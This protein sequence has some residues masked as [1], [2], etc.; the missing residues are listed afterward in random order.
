MIISR[1][2]G[3]KY[4]I[5]SILFVILSFNLFGCEGADESANVNISSDMDIPEDGI[6]KADVFSAIAGTKEEITF[7]GKD[8][9]IE[10]EWI[11]SGENIHNPADSNLSIDFVTDESKLLEIK[12]L[13]GNPTYALGLKLDNEE[14]VTIPTL[15]ITLPYKWDADVAVLC[16]N[17]NNTAMKLSDAEVKV[18]NDSTTLTMQISEAN[19]LYYVVA[20][21]SKETAKERNESQKASEEKD[22]AQDTESTNND[23]DNNNSEVAD[24]NSEKNQVTDNSSKKNK[25]SDNKSEKNTQ[26]N[27]K[28]NKEAYKEKLSCTISIDC[29][30]IL[31]NY[32]RLDKSKKNFVPDNGVILPETKV[33]FEKGDSVFDILLK[34][35]KDNNIQMEH[36]YT[37][38]YGSEYI[39]GIN[40]LYE[41]DCGELSG[42]MFSVGGW[43][44]NY[45]CDKYILSGGEKIKWSYTC[46]LGKDL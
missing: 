23:K 6:I 3:I 42:W 39:E 25:E 38:I 24:N 43:S 31:S 17:E 32:D 35:C 41:F 12:K 22:S 21:I 30:T 19:D 5:I 4:F 8:E 36:S 1:K 10:Y 15:R 2:K 44:P 27:Y 46:D 34:V 14:L 37:P 29:K 45:G 20:G 11:F 9:E 26:N 7:H 13:S 33:E 40:Q 28:E 18:G 16:K